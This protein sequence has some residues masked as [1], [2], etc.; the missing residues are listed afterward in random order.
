MIIQGSNVPLRIELDAE[1]DV[2]TLA[3][4]SVA[5]SLLDGTVLKHWNKSDC[6]IS[7]DCG[8]IE[9]PITQSESMDWTPTVCR[10]ELKWVDDGRINFAYAEDKICAW[11]D[12]E[13][14]KV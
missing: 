2:K 5:L 3:D 1:D 6:I 8:V 11:A 9:C 12:K 10:I 14:L 13:V 4:I 7:E